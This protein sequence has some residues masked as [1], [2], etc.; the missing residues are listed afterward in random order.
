[1]TFKL[2][3]D[4]FTKAVTIALSLAL[5]VPQLAIAG[6]DPVRDATPP[7]SGSAPGVIEIQ[8]TDGGF[9]VI[10]D[11]DF[12]DEVQATV[13]GITG[14]AVGAAILPEAAISDI[15]ITVANGASSTGAVSPVQIAQTVAEQVSRLKTI[16]IATSN[17]ALLTVQVSP[18]ADSTSL[19]VAGTTPSQMQFSGQPAAIE[20]Q[21]AT[22]A[23]LIVAQATPETT[24]AGTSIASSGVGSTRVV[25]L[26]LEFQ[27]LVSD[28]TVAQSQPWLVASADLSTIAQARQVQINPRQLNQAIAAYNAMVTE[29]PPEAL[30]T[31]SKNPDFQAIGTVL[32]QLKSAID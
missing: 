11:A 16:T 1:M 30:S 26:M 22:A 6:T 12:P 14:D 24:A 10:P 7:D 3:T 32:R 13:D 4:S 5:V 28:L 20:H 29:C 18:T 17:P 2:L 25:T 15:T 19:T 8:Q 21:A 23:A 27:N 31:L 9:I